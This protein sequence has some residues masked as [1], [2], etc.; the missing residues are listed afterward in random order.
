[1]LDGGHAS[2]AKTEAVEWGL[3]GAAMTFTLVILKGCVQNKQDKKQM[4]NVIKWSDCAS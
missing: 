4:Q 1:M 2:K 3:H